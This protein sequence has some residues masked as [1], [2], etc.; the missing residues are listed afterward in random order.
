MKTNPGNR[1][2]LLATVPKGGVCAEL[3]VFIGEFSVEIALICQ[4]SKLWLVDLFTGTE[5]S[6]GADGK[7]NMTVNLDQY[8]LI[9]KHFFRLMPCAEL[10]KACSYEWL[11]KQP[12]NSLGM[13]YIDSAHDYETTRKELDSAERAVKSGGLICGH[14]YAPRFPGV[15]QAVNEFVARNGLEAEIF[16]G[17]RLPSYRIVNRK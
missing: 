12:E 5:M 7:V 4:P 13:V 9:A 6:G 1:L 2:D 17:D 8:F 11:Q 15:I 3:G 10:V 16:T 14:D